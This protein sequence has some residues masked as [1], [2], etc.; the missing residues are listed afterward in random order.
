MVFWGDRAIKEEKVKNNPTQKR[1]NLE[2]Y[3]TF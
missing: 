3:L 1:K 2:M